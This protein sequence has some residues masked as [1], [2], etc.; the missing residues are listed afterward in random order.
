[1]DSKGKRKADITNEGERLEGN[2][3]GF[4]GL[5]KIQSLILGL[6]QVE[7]RKRDHKD[8]PNPALLQNS[9]HNHTPRRTRNQN[10]LQSVQA[11]LGTGAQGPKP[12]ENRNSVYKSQDEDL[13]V[14]KAPSHSQREQP[15][16]DPAQSARTLPV[17]TEEAQDKLL[18]FVSNG[19]GASSGIRNKMSAH[20]I[21]SRARARLA[22]MKEQSDALLQA[23]NIDGPLESLSCERDAVGRT[24]LE[25]DPRAGADA[26]T[27]AIVLVSKQ[28]EPGLPV[29]HGTAGRGPEADPPVTSFPI[30][31]SGRNALDL[32][33][34]LLNKLEEEKRLS[35]ESRYETKTEVAIPTVSSSLDRSLL[36]VG[37]ES[38][39]LA[40]AISVGKDPVDAQALEA[41]L[42]V[43]A[44]LR[45][46]LAAE[47]R[48]SPA[49]VPG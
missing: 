47:K 29:L 27:S 35:S 20:E 12:R 45:V 7:S 5:R 24:R 1:M 41:K 28:P 40:G 42:R 16:A 17:S 26:V 36:P 46:R 37:I 9:N 19:D 13:S 39:R 25:R 38:P 8:G 18:S 48:G 15:P 22:K 14:Q 43:R 21:M 44:Q 31:K 32:H 2:D 23:S 30:A 6:D 3:A 49:V 4:T 33:A 34:K 10:L 11:H